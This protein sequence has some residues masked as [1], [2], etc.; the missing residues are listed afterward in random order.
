MLM[1]T[2]RDDMATRLQEAHM[3]FPSGWQLPAFFLKPDSVSCQ[4]GSFLPFFKAGFPSLRVSSCLPYLKPDSLPVRLAVSC[5]FFKSRIPFPVRLEARLFKPDSI[6][7]QVGSFP[8]FLK[9]GHR[10]RAVDSF[11]SFFFKTWYRSRQVGSFLPCKNRTPFSW[12]WQ[13]PAFSKN[14]TS[15]P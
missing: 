3:S 13:F 7:C 6:S 15:F 9:T 1:F 10:S 5:L 12:G 2:E 14:R 8:P 11:P 4:V